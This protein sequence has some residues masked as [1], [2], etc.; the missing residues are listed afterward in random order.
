MTAAP[1]RRIVDSTL[2]PRTMLVAQRSRHRIRPFRLHRPKT[3]EEA[4]AIRA[5]NGAAAYMS[6]G[7]DVVAGLKAGA[8]L[9]D[10]IHL[11]S[12]RSWTSL[13]E[14]HDA[15]AVGAGVTHQGL[16]DSSLLRRVYPGL[17]SAWSG[18]ANYRIR[19]KGTLAGNLMARNASYDFAMAAIAAGARLEYRDSNRTSGEVPAERLS[20]IPQQALLTNIIMPR[21]HWLAFAVQYQWKPLV[22][23]ALSF[24]RVQDAVI[25]RL[26]VGCGYHAV[27]WSDVRLEHGL[28]DRLARETPADIAERLCASLPLPASDWRASSEYRRHLLKV[29]TRREIERIR[30]EGAPS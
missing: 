13:V 6:G 23:F 7:I 21:G 5:E 12:L 28:F 11:G 22:A 27:T 9:T 20:D 10:V 14:H 18:L 24:K 15:I 19:I 25:G 29:L 30:A 26:A 3:A 16:A 17:C 1:Y 2:E 4:V 8:V